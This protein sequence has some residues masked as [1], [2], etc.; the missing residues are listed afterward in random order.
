MSQ[1]S[2]KTVNNV[3]LYVNMG[4]DHLGLLLKEQE[5]GGSIFRAYNQ[6]G[7]RF[8]KWEKITLANHTMHYQAIWN[9]V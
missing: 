1:I 6:F 7:G 3:R 5:L 9:H 8:A 4:S 2:G